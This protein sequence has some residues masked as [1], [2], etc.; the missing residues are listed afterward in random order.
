[1]LWEGIVGG[2]GD[3]GGQAGSLSDRADKYAGRSGISRLFY[4]CENRPSS[5]LYMLQL[6]YV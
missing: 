2:I 3:G 5:S 6:S 1:M 4:L